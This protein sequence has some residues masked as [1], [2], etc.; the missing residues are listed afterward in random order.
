MLKRRSKT[1]NTP[2]AAMPATINEFEVLPPVW[3]CILLKTQVAAPKLAMKL[4]K[5][6]DIV[7][8]YH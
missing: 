6:F 4:I 8:F 3:R 1:T 7:I 5:A 2:A